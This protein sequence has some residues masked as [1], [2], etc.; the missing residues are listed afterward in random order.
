MTRMYKTDLYQQQATPLKTKT[1]QTSCLSSFYVMES[2]HSITTVVLSY[3][4][5]RRILP[6]RWFVLFPNNENT[7]PKINWC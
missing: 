6:G 2:I 5:E 1:K 4:F 7:F 3:V